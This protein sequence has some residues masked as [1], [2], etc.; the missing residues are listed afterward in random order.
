MAAQQ[1]PAVE[2]EA[3]NVLV[4]REDG[5]YDL[6]II[7]TNN[8]IHSLEAG[9]LTLNGYGFSTDGCEISE[10]GKVVTVK[11]RDTGS[12]YVHLSTE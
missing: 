4:D 8:K 1:A 7:D 11:R 12:R 9:A 2:I 3:Q 10:Y 6:R 5:R